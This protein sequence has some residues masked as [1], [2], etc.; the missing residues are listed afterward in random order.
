MAAGNFEKCHMVT[1][2]YEG[3]WSDHPSDPGGA[4][5][6]GITI[7]KYRE[8][9]PNATPAQLRNISKATALAI[10]KSD[11]W[12]KINAEGLAAGVDLAVYDLAVNSGTG[13]AKQYLLASVGGTDVQTVKKVC[14]KRLGFMQALKTWKVFGKGWARRVAGIE[15]KGVAWALAASAAAGSKVVPNKIAMEEEAKAI[16]KDAKA[17]GA[18]GAAVG[19]GAV[20]NVDASNSTVL[21]V[22]VGGL[23][24]LCLYLAYRAYVNKQRSAAYAEEAK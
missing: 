9:F 19:G 6:Y 2:V 7:G 15:A 23:T 4:T 10:Y 8:H 14:A 16:A 18:G 17:Q 13:R 24:V 21:W 1:A 20:Y 5:M 12:D 3:G 11:Y 22:I